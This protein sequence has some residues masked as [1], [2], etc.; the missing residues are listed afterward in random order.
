[1]VLAAFVNQ[2]PVGGL[3]AHLLPM[4]YT[5]NTEVMIYDLAVSETHQRQGIGGALIDHVRQL[6]AQQGIETVFV[7]VDN[8]DLHALD[9]YR[10]Q[11]GQASPTTVF[12]F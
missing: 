9:F 2:E 11:H 3:T 10:K 4:T 5:H 7:V 12:E 1:L 8:E 6:A